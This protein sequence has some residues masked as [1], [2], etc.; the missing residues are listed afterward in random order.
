MGTQSVQTAEA[1][2]QRPG[3]Q[4]NQLKQTERCIKKNTRPQHKEA[5]VVVV[6]A[7]AATCTHQ[8]EA[9]RPDE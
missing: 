1:L 4:K 3:T 7:A 9:P 5:D 8:V 2:H 6:A